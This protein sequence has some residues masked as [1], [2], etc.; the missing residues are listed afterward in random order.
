VERV[1]RLEAGQEALVPFVKLAE[2]LK[3]RGVSPD[4]VD[5]EKI[6]LVVSLM[7]GGGDGPG[8]GAMISG[9]MSSMFPGV[10]FGGKPKAKQADAVVK[11]AK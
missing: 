5:D 8:L 10:P 2:K 7:G 9:A 4:D 6:D 3:A 1:A 11:D